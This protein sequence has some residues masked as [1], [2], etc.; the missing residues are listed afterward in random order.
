MIDAKVDDHIVKT[1]ATAARLEAL[2][3]QAVPPPVELRAPIHPWLHVD[4]YGV[5]VGRVTDAGACQL[6]TSDRKRIDPA[7]LAA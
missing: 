7:K 2:S 3:E 1:R 5:I 6:I 4:D